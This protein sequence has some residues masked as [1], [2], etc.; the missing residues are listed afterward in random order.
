MGPSS[1][2]VRYHIQRRRRKYIID[3]E[4][5]ADA[6]RKEG[7]KGKAWREKKILTQRITVGGPR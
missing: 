3:K 5:A 2:T 1:K 7:R 4:N 6:I